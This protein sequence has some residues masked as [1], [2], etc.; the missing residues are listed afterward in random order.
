MLNLVEDRRKIL[1]WRVEISESKNDMILRLKK[2]IRQIVRLDP[3]SLSFSE[4]GITQKLAN[5]I[6]E[7]PIE[8][9]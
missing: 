4:N 1:Q 8:S 6:N 2:L 5:N 7:F 9:N 3:K